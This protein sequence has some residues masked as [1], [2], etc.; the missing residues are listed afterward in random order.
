M[1]NQALLDYVGAQDKLTD[2]VKW[3]EVK[4]AEGAYYKTQKLHN[5]FWQSTFDTAGALKSVVASIDLS[6]VFASASGTIIL[7]PMQ[8]ILDVDNNFRYV[9]LVPTDATGNWLHTIAM[10]GNTVILPPAG[11]QAAA[12]ISSTNNVIVSGNSILCPSGIGVA[13]SASVNRAVIGPNVSANA[14]F[15]SSAYCGTIAAGTNITTYG[16]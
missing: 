12:S 10:S 7:E 9:S 13:T 14:T 6:S 5:L 8:E 3:A 15:T 4:D 16:P 1:K 2:R 11:G